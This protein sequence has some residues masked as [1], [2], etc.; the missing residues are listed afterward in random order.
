MDEE[1]SDEVNAFLFIRSLEVKKQKKD[2]KEQESKANRAP[3][4]AR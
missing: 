1:P 3:S 4:S 2:N